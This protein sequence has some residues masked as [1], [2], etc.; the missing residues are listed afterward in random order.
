MTHHSRIALAFMLLPVAVAG[1]SSESTKYP[2]S[3]VVTLDGVPAPLVIVSFI[4]VQPDLI[5]GGSGATDSAGKFTIGEEGKNSGLTR[6]DYK[7]T[8]SQTLVRGKPT[9][10]GSGGKAAEKEATEREAVADD[11]RNPQTTP[12][13]AT[14]KSGTN[15]F[16]FEIQAKK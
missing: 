4:P 15:N 10:A 11:F 14:I 7:V 13:T 6:G 8:F 9:L 2:V 5:A 12:V 1:C 3:G 16:T